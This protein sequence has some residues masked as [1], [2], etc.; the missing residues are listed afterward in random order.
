M[1]TGF[2]SQQLLVSALCSS[3]PHEQ[4]VFHLIHLVISTPRYPFLLN[5]LRCQ[6][7]ARPEAMN[8]LIQRSTVPP[9]SANPYSKQLVT[10]WPPYL[11]FGFLC[12]Y[13]HNRRAKTNRQRRQRLT[14]SDSAHRLDVTMFERVLHGPCQPLFHHLFIFMNRCSHWMK[15]SSLN[16]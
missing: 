4:S 16:A 12:V 9:T 1:K 13:L 3:I 14:T 6:E 11:T 15:E 8:I 10:R 7:Y 5:T 2:C